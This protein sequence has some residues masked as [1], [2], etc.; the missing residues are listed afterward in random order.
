MQM[1]KVG[2]KENKNNAYSIYAC[3]R[4]GLHRAIPMKNKKINIVAIAFHVDEAMRSHIISEASIQLQNWVKL[5]LLW[6]LS[7]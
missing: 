1:Q 6:I 2:K 5:W 4:S 3:S 7:R